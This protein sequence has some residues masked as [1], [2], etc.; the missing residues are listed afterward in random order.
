MKGVACAVALLAVGIGT[1]GAVAGVGAAAPRDLIVSADRTPTVTGEIYRVDLDGHR[2]DLSKSPFQDTQPVVSPD[3]RSVAFVSDRSGRPAIYVAGIGGGPAQRVSTALTRPVIA[4]WAPDGR[5]LA[6][7]V[8]GTQNRSLLYLVGPGMRQ[9]A[10]VGPDDPCGAEAAAWS[11]DGSAIA[12]S[13]CTGGSASV[14]VIT[15]GGRSVFSVPSAARRTILSWSPAGQLAVTSGRTIRIFDARGRL[16][17]R[18]A[19]D[20]IAWSVSGDRLASIARG[21]VEVRDESGG[22]RRVVQTQ[23][24]PETEIRAIITHSHD[25]EPEI[26]WIGSTHVAVGNVALSDTVSGPTA[27]SPY[28]QVSGGIDAAT[29]ARWRP[30]Q[31]AWFAASCG[32]ANAG[33]SR[34]ATTA[35]VGTG[36]ALQVAETSAP[37]ARS[38]ARLPGCMDDGVLVAAAV[39]FQFANAGASVVYQSNCYE[40]AAN[41]YAV[42][43]AG[44]AIRRLTRTTAQQTAPAW[45]PDGSRVAFVQADA[46]G[47]SCKGCPST[48]W[49]MQA[50][51]SG[52]RALTSPADSTWDA[53][54]S[55]SPDGSRVIYAQSTISDFGELYVVAAAGGTPVDLHVAG[56]SPAWGP[57]RIAYLGGVA[58]GGP[59]ISL[60]T[61]RPDGTDRRKLATG[62]ISSPAWSRDGRIAYL[63]G[64]KPRLAVRAGGTT[65][66]FPLPL[67]EV[68]S[69]SW[70][71]DGRHLDVVGRALPTG[72][73]DVYSIGADGRSLTRIT[74]NLGVLGASSRP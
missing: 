30:S 65:R 23:L 62:V 70:A 61:M 3:G 14:R 60:W 51:G 1:P 74:A 39:G 24:F 38:I 55:W 48:I 35:K 10:L 8:G 28:A 18:F 37:A 29:G 40:P 58:I 46:T 4:G 69:V 2:V 50:D 64:A 12:F 32:C 45:S 59:H 26:Q 68:G 33:G 6:I 34:F 52:A 63:V 36:F 43:P 44:G 15:P 56:G 11:P 57:S 7:E 13:G 21:R 22:G 47:S 5:E 17:A 27:A 20:A 71:A 31:R 53:S 72:V 54:P 42:D 25:Y 9:R 67:A 41:L 49:S 19:A 66:T 16:L 73:S